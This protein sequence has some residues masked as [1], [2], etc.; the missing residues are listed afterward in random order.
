MISRSI[1][2]NILILSKTK[3]R[4][5]SVAMVTEQAEW[6]PTLA[7]G[8]EDWVDS[9]PVPQVEEEEDGE[10]HPRESEAKLFHQSLG[11]GIYSIVKRELS[12]NNHGAK[13]RMAAQ[14]LI[15][16]SVY[17]KRGMEW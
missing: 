11:C 17:I 4:N 1:L 9:V 12:Y 14:Q 10:D 13:T 15:V 6:S 2:E 7:S 16:H 5:L 8:T 3:T